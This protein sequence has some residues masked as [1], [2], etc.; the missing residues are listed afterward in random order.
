VSSI[1][2]YL[3]APDLSLLQEF[4]N[5]EG[6]IAFILPSRNGTFEM[7]DSVKLEPNHKYTL[8]HVPSGPVPADCRD[9]Q[10]QIAVDPTR[11]VHPGA[12]DLRLEVSPGKYQQ[13]IRRSHGDGYELKLFDDTTA[14]GRSGFGFL[15][16]KFNLVGKGA[17]PSTVRWWQRLRRWVS[18]H[19]RRVTWTGE[20]EG[21]ESELRVWAFPF[22]YAA[23]KSGRPRSVNPVL[24]GESRGR[25]FAKQ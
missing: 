9:A 4:L 3:D 16:N 8:W 13:L 19:G 14:I 22:A 1:L 20:L 6:D 18:K 25:L 23:L 10:G 21:P 2:V 7:K 11:G 5:D 12:I 24:W 17:H 15:G